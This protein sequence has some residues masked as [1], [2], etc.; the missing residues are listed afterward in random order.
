[1]QKDITWRA[2]MMHNTKKSFFL[3]LIGVL[4]IIT[5]VWFRFIKERLPRD[6]P[7]NLSLISLTVIIVISLSYLYIMY[8]TFF[9]RSSKINTMLKPI[10]LFL[11]KPLVSSNQLILNSILGKKILLFSSDIMLKLLLLRKK[12]HDSFFIYSFTFILPKALFG[13]CFLID[14]FYYEQLYLIYRCAFVISLPLIIKYLLYCSQHIYD[15]PEL[16]K[17]FLVEITSKD[18]VYSEN[19]FDDKGFLKLHLPVRFWNLSDMEFDIAPMT[20]HYNYVKLNKVI[21]YQSTEL[22]SFDSPHE[23]KVLHIDER[24]DVIFLSDKPSKHTSLSTKDCENILNF[25]ININILKQSFDFIREYYLKNKTNFNR[26]N[27]FINIWNGLILFCW[28]YILT[29]SLHTLPNDAFS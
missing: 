15:I 13:I 26:L 10:V 20:T 2:K 5:F 19:D 11:L 23:Y 28:V 21:L 4:F 7:F 18:I 3:S 14:C 25:Y 29:K 17:Y 16:E 12:Q 8:K 27:F 6:I 24:K 1:M 22:W 9:T